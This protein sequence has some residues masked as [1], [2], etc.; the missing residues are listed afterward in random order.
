MAAC[1]RWVAAEAAC[2]P[3]GL[4]KLHMGQTFME[5]HSVAEAG[6]HQV[7]PPGSLPLASQLFFRGNSQSCCL[8]VPGAPGSEGMPVSAAYGPASV[9]MAAPDTIT[10]MPG[11]QCPLGQL[12]VS[13]SMSCLVF[14]GLSYT[15]CLW[16]M[17]GVLA[18]AAAW[19][20]SR[21][22]LQSV[23]RKCQFGL[24]LYSPGARSACRLAFVASG[25]AT[26]VQW[27]LDPVPSQGLQ[28]VKCHP[29]LRA[30]PRCSNGICNG[31]LG[32]LQSCCAVL[33]EVRLLLP[34]RH[35]RLLLSWGALPPRSTKPLRLRWGLP[36]VSSGCCFLA[37]TLQLL[38]SVSA[39]CMQQPAHGAI[40]SV[41]PLPV[42]VCTAE[43]AGVL[44]SKSM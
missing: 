7:W 16:H 4:F 1:S 21:G 9:A 11:A 6:V 12:G 18:K 3:S 36:W 30:S 8:Q 27:P 19:P 20:F 44:C 29:A 17:P 15:C 24:Q 41:L 14:C 31:Q 43:A 38:L 42:Q 2:A 28:V 25:A 5:S 40:F 23:Q 35:W 10:E 37:P 33:Q 34:S 13:A 22:G 39:H 32:A 26:L